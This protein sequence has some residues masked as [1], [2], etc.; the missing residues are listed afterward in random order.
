MDSPKR[1]MPPHDC[2]GQQNG[3]MDILV[4]LSNIEVIVTSDNDDFDLFNEDNGYDDD[5]V[6]F[7]DN[8]DQHNSVPVLVECDVV[9][10]DGDDDEEDEIYVTFFY[11]NRQV[12]PLVR[13]MVLS[14]TCCIYLFLSAANGE[15]RKH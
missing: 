14:N 9:S 12:L 6:V 7:E 4:D 1:P 3:R 5:D 15:T 8:D 11:L 2:K 13:V 10:N